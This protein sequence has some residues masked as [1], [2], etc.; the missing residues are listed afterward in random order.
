[1]GKI[2]LVKLEMPT[3]SVWV[4]KNEIE[5]FKETFLSNEIVVEGSVQLDNQPKKFKNSEEHAS[6]ILEGVSNEA[7][8]SFFSRK[9]PIKT[10]NIDGHQHT[11]GGGEHITDRASELL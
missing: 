7:P 2:N 6:N 9:K 4:R 11:I 10:I 3:M 8:T 1:M 5:L